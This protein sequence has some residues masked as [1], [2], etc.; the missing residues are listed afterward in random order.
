MT[1]QRLLLRLMLKAAWVRKDRALMALLSIAVVAAMATVALTVYSDLEGKLSHEFR[2]FGANAIAVAG[3]GSL[4]QDEL[5]RMKKTLGEKSE[6]VP[7]RYA[8]VAGPAGN[9]IVVGGTDLRAFHRLNASWSL[10]V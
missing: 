3:K 10:T 8:V 2:N 1:R 5:A 4:S 9:R 7:L 6:V